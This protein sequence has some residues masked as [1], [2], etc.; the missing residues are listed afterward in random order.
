MGRLLS[1]KSVPETLREVQ[2]VRVF[3]GTG[4]GTLF[5]VPRCPPHMFPRLEMD[6]GIGNFAH[7]SS[8]IQKIEVFQRVASEEGGRVALAVM[9]ERLIVAYLAGWY[10]SPDER[11]SRL[12]H[13]M[14][15]M[16]A[17]EVSRN[18]RNMGIAAKLFLT[19]MED[20]FFEDKIA[21]MNGFS[22]HWDLD[23]SGLTI[24]RYRAMMINLLNKGGFQEVYTN[25]P[26][27][28]LR[29]E[30][31]FMVRIGSRV[32]EQDLARFRDLRFG[33]VRR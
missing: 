23:G 8:I 4:P 17:I 9:G 11:W 18:F 33:I 21:Y 30:N 24:A 19:I 6:K 25:E 14:Y 27:I 12:D 13:V 15:E 22:W 5:I 16:G 28:A 3:E 2:D 20:D 31:L 1:F 29:Q 10:P 7:Y 32:S 26:N